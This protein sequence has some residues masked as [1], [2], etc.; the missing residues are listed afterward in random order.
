[1]H[2]TIHGLDWIG[3]G[4]D[5]QETVNWIGFGHMSATPFFLIGPITSTLTD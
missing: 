3:L 5:L 2:W 4:Q 1:M